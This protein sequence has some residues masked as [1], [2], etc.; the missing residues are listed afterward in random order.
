MNKEEID[1]IINGMEFSIWYLKDKI[2]KEEYRIYDLSSHF[3]D[4]LIELIIFDRKEE[5][6]EYIGLAEQYFND[7]NPINSAKPLDEF[8]LA[9]I[10]YY[11]F[12]F[13]LIKNNPDYQLLNEYKIFKEKYKV[14]HYKISKSNYV[15][16]EE[17][18]L[19]F[20]LSKDYEKAKEYCNKLLAIND[21]GLV[22]VINEYLLRKE[23]GEE[24]YKDLIKE[25]K[26]ILNKRRSNIAHLLPNGVIYYNFYFT[27]LLKVSD[28][29]KMFKAMVF[30]IE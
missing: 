26:A 11:K 17:L 25:C 8:D 18:V 27:E 2:E 22:S 15:S 3:L 6:K 13:S 28:N 23:K 14:E 7:F 1:G 4:L 19:V 24:D 9:D 21:K 5:L 16:Y 30:G 12:L 29:E 10:K 20:I